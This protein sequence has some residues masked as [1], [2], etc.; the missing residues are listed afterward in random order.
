VYLKNCFNF[1]WPAALDL[2]EEPI[3]EKFLY[4]MLKNLI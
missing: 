1:V 2:N 3:E 4:G